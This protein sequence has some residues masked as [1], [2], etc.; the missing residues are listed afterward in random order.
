M[1]R[2]PVVERV[3]RDRA[4]SARRPRSTLLPMALA[5]AIAAGVLAAP[6][7]ARA[8]ALGCTIF[9]GGELC[10]HVWGEGETIWAMTS[11][12]YLF[13]EQS[14]MCDWRIDWVIY[15][16]SQVWWR[17]V[18][19]RNGCV[20]GDKEDYVGNRTR[21]DGWAPDGSRFCAELYAGSRKVDAA[22]IGIEK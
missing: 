4:R 10:F 18:G 16:G 14:Q 19:P 20:R 9:S 2:K 22:C 12:F 8:S 5:A 1:F 3:S 13:N 17:S 11:Y 15:Q 7:P 21:G 6:A